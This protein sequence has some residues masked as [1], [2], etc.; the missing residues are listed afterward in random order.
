MKFLSCLVFLYTLFCYIPVVSSVT[1]TIGGK[2]KFIAVDGQLY[3]T[4]IDSSDNSISQLQTLAQSIEANHWQ[5]YSEHGSPDFVIHFH[6]SFH[7]IVGVQITIHSPDGHAFGPLSGQFGVQH[8]IEQLQ[9]GELSLDIFQGVPPVNAFT[10][11]VLGAINSAIT[12]GNIPQAAHLIPY[13]LSSISESLQVTNTEQYSW[14]QSNDGNINFVFQHQEANADDELASVTV[15]PIYNDKKIMKHG[16]TY[17]SIKEN[18]NLITCRGCGKIF[19][20]ETSIG[21]PHGCSW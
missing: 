16:F 4:S 9:S 11:G 10:E 5:I 13:S 14:Q 17:K 20:S 7:S 3:I 19:L 8:F 21:N 12:K 1:F 6:Q 15:T 2:I 18:L